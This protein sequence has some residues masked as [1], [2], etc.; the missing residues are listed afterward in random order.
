[1]E[2]QLIYKTSFYMVAAI[3]SFV[4]V[5]FVL[6]EGW[7]D[8]RQ[9]RVFFI[10]LL[11]VIISAV[12]GIIYKMSMPYAVDNHDLATFML[13]FQ[14]LDFFAHTALA[15]LFFIYVQNVTGAINNASHNRRLMYMLPF[16]MAECM[17][18]LN[19]VIGWIYYFDESYNFYRNWGETVTYG[20]AAYY[21][22]LSAFN[23]L[24]YWHAVNR[25]RRWGL[26][27]SFIITLTG[28]VIQLMSVDFSVELVTEAMGLVVIMLVVEREDDRLDQSTRTYNR[29][30]FQTDIDNIFRIGQQFHMIYVRILNG[31]ILQRLTGS[32][33]DD[34][35]FREVV[36]FLREVHSK[37]QIYRVNDSSFALV[38]Y[39]GEKEEVV[40]QAE[41]IRER[42]EESFNCNGVDVRLKTMIL[43]ASIPEELANRSE[44]MQLIDSRFFEL[45]E[46]RVLEGRDISRLM[47]NVALERALHRGIEEHNYEVHYQ[48]IYNMPDKSIFGAEARIS[49]N[50]PELGVVD[51]KQILPLAER[52]GIDLIIENMLLDEVCMFLGS[53]IPA[54]LGMLHISVGLSVKQCLQ[55]Y[56]LDMLDRLIEKYKILPSYINFEVPEPAD[57]EQYRQLSEIMREL[58]DRGFML[59]LEGYGTGYTNMQSFSNMGYD[60]VNMDAGMLGENELTEVG[61]SILK[62]SIRM[63]RDM[64]MQILI[65]EGTTREQVEWIEH[66]DVNY[67]QSDYYSKVVTQ[68]ELISILR[69]TEIARQDEQRARAG[70]EAKSNFLANM[71]HE[72]RTPINAILGMNEMILRESRNEAVIEYAKDIESASRSLLALINDILDFSK[73]EAGNMEIVPV[74]YDL[75][76]LLHDVI[77]MTQ[78]RVEQTE[79]DFVIDVDQSLPEKLYGDE[80]RIRQVLLNLLNNAVKYTEKGSVTFSVKGSFSTEHNISLIFTVSDTGK[81]I[82]KE[83]KDKLFATL[84]RLDERT[85]RTIEGTGL[86]L[87]I[88]N[89]LINLMEGSLTVES[90]YGKGSVFTTVVPQVVLDSKP[91]GDINA[92]YSE[93]QEARLEY[94]EKFIA[95]EANILIVD[96]TPMN[97]T[98]I[99][100]LLKQTQIKIDT[101]LSGKE[102]LELSAVKPYD[103]IFLDYRMPE[104][105]GVTTLKIMRGMSEHPNM[106]TPIILL[107]ANALSG[108]REQF[109]A[110]GFDD[111][112]TKPVDGRKLEEL[113]FNY[114]P[115]DKV[116]LQEEGMGFDGKDKFNRGQNVGTDGGADTAGMDSVGNSG[117]LTGYE[118]D[119]SMEELDSELR[120]KLAGLSGFDVDQGISFCGSPDGYLEVLGIYVDSARQKASDIERF[121][122]AEDYENYTIQV[123]SLKS[124]SKLIGAFDISERARE[125]EEAGNDNNIELIKSNTESLLIDF[126]KLGKELANLLP[127]EEAVEEAAGEDISEDMLEDAYNTLSEFAAVM[128][129]E[130]AVF[131]INE[132]KGYRLSEVER[133]RINR[134]LAAVE[135]LDW[136]ETIACLN[137]RG[138]R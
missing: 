130:N 68:N 41:R 131:I 119:P 80:L 4:A 31:D 72:I 32:F 124:T 66:T 100:S 57:S 85:D 13:I 1:M 70:S 29:S 121:Y 46:N 84:Q 38:Y 60:I 10:M 102:C 24:F 93:K 69:V 128:D 86:G 53:G 127:K 67:L 87:A 79:L 104:M 76:S 110:E 16:I 92:R 123:H 5:V 26:L 23:M 82:K 95:P 74:E 58:K 39:N 30:A 64:H 103:I 118:A 9:T 125:L 75:S 135:R 120:D 54:E 96:D 45:N 98:V 28:I 50:D 115:K 134:I 43:V 105:D 90:E 35:L 129:Y 36:L 114:L 73:I 126:R 6:V 107:T 27:Y 47:Y 99:K 106:H 122:R 22:I 3:I 42:F 59:S 18:L 111:Y 40:D 21:F 71:S 25:R 109:M 81:G 63:I 19:P 14:F 34:S 88:S 17:V 49:L 89:N 91:I 113:L 116:I 138:G 2:Y 117:G 44:I 20:V 97:L 132:L 51:D 48:P 136:E 11:D 33:D 101:A 112:M 133:D 78:M 52:H 137:E 61:K 55:P 83:D 65:K 37:Y 12:G 56:F 8:R 77:N 15:P 7:L 108:A 94:H 62:H